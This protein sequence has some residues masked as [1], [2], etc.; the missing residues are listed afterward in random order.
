MPRR[1]YIETNFIL[2]VANGQHEANDK[3]IDAVT[4][5]VLELALPQICIDEAISANVKDRE[6][7]QQHLAPLRPEV[8]EYGRSRQSATSRAASSRLQS[9]IL[10]I[11]KADGE[12]LARLRTILSY[13]IKT[14]KLL[15]AVLSDIAIEE[16]LRRDPFDAII[17][18][19]VADE[20]RLFGYPSL[21]LTGNDDFDS[22]A[23]RGTLVDAG[24]ERV[25]HPEKLLAKL[26]GQKEGGPA[27]R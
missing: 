17:A 15:P 12:R 22:T 27:W 26:R 11:E 13:L 16:E 7:M 10:A 1:V 2:S 21:L 3:I 6:R 9:A 23:L 14:A 24:V 8:R 5:G 19:A 20:N 4:V 25:H 18:K